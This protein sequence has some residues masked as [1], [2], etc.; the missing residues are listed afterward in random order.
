MRNFSN[1]HK[2]EEFLEVYDLHFM[3]WKDKNPRFLE[4]GVQFGGSLQI[5]REYFKKIQLVGVDILES[6][7]QYAS[8]DTKIYIGDQGNAH[9]L[10]SL[11]KFDII[12]DDGGHTM[13]QQQTSFEV[14]FEKLSSGGI[15]VIEDVHTSY[16][17]QF[18]DTLP[19]TIDYC[20]ALV[21][22]INAD[23]THSGRN[24]NFPKR[25]NT[26]DI[27]SIHFYESVVVIV[28]K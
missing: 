6:C 16:W 11:G 21:D 12:V 24:E 17:K 3:P 26:F 8:E 23:A 27:K 25:E 1:A 4:I 19:T 20:K 13:N 7:S 14:L 5:W 9:F 28:K 15:Y 22:D 18:L 10:D 2:K